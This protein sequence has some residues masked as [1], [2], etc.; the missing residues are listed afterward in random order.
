MSK[1]FFPTRSEVIK[2]AC[3]DSLMR[4]L[5]A[6]EEIDEFIFRS[7]DLLERIQPLISGRIV[8][9]FT[10]KE[11][12]TINGIVIYE[13]SPIAGKMIKGSTGRWRFVAIDHLDTFKNLSDLRVG[14]GMQY[15]AKVKHIIDE[16]SALISGR[17]ELIQSIHAFRLLPTTDAA[18][19]V[20]RGARLN[21]LSPKIEK[22][23][24]VDWK[25]DAAG[26]W[27]KV[28]EA[29]SKRYEDRQRRKQARILATGTAKP[30]RKAK[31]GAA[32][33]TAGKAKK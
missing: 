4:L 13:Y 5:L 22:S 25:D 12:W 26:S 6:L 1:S 32:G 8:F 14:K 16:I 2:K 19:L 33:I 7:N 11:K 27:A 20:A 9:L 10:K 3:D 17:K 21:K 18:K 29:A 28:K 30:K 24:N 23:L 15:D 31:A